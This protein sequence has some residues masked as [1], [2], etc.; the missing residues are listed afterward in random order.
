MPNPLLSQCLNTLSNFKP[1]T[2]TFSWETLSGVVIGAAIGFAGNYLIE[3]SKHGREQRKI[4]LEQGLKIIEAVLHDYEGLRN[5]I[6]KLTCEEDYLSSADLR[7]ILKKER[8]NFIRAATLSYFPEIDELK[9]W[10]DTY[11]EVCRT[12]L[13][14]ENLQ[15]DKVPTEHLIKLG[16]LAQITADAKR[17]ITTALAKAINNGR[18]RGI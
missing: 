5:Y 1:K 2:D 4:R 12:L 7:E 14:F 6:F 16:D 17:N 18:S 13:A 3:K 15:I 8:L 10:D 9:L 11:C